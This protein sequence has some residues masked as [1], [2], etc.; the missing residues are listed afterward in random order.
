MFEDPISAYASIERLRSAG[1]LFNWLDLDPLGFAEASE[2]DVVSC[3]QVAEKEAV[4]CLTNGGWQAERYGKPTKMAEL[5]ASGPLRVTETE[6]RRRHTAMVRRIVEVEAAFR[7]EQAARGGFALVPLVLYDGRNGPGGVVRSY[8]L[9]SRGDESGWSCSHIK[10]DPV[11]GLSVIAPGLL[12]EAGRLEGLPPS[13]EMVLV[14]RFAET[15]S[16]NGF[17]APGQSD[18]LRQFLRNRVEYARWRLRRE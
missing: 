15:G 10:F 9:L 5:L 3:Y 16:A 2:I 13:R 7:I 14:L 6:R 4:M 18:W 11:D 8:Y 1:W 17:L 12:A